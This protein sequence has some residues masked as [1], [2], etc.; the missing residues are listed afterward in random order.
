MI[1]SVSRP[2]VEKAVRFYGSGSSG[3]EVPLFN[4]AQFA[5]PLAYVSTLS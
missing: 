3:T 5:Q 4:S 2:V 1:L